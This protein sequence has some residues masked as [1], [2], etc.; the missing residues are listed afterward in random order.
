MRTATV[1]SCP[2]SAVREDNK[3]AP[4][5]TTKSAASQNRGRLSPAGSYLTI[6]DYS[7]LERH[8]RDIGQKPGSYASGLSQLIRRKL[9]DAYMVFPSDV[10]ADAVTGNSRI[11]FAI[12]GG[13]EECRIIVHRAREF[14]P[15]MTL[16]VATPLGVT[17]LG[18]TAGQSAPL[19]RGVGTTGTVKLIAVEFQPERERRSAPLRHEQ[20]HNG[21]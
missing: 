18:M 1:E 13:P 2:E 19:P 5:N 11:M 4:V 9:A 12:A 21:K 6:R 15:G 8:L 14:V 3:P 10:P 17:L 16:L 7:Q 20:G